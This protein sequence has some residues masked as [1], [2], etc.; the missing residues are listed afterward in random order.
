MGKKELAEKYV[1]FLSGE[2]YRP[3]L[4]EQQDVVFKKEGLSFIILV[5]PSDSLYFR[6]VCPNI[7]S[8][9][10]EKSRCRILV[11]CD[12][13]NYGHKVAKLYLVNNKVWATG[14]TFLSGPEAYKPVFERI[15]SVLLRSVSYFV[16]EVAQPL[17]ETPGTTSSTSAKAVTAESAK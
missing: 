1:S 7:W 5:D 6:V 4:D 14:E 11:A 10:E 16:K 17:P 12:K 8:A 3:S 2:G 15:M 13:T 9:E